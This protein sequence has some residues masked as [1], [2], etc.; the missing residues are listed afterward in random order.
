MLGLVFLGRQNTGGLTGLPSARNAVRN[1]GH[2]L[3][4]IDLAGRT[5]YC[6]GWA[7]DYAWLGLLF[8][9]AG[10]VP[11]FKLESVNRLLDDEIDVGLR[12]TEHADA[13][14]AAPGA[15]LPP[16]AA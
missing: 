3:R 6:D 16:G 5:V 12:L 11:R 4:V 14:P 13:P 7:H 8:E 9:E 15:S 1:S 2:H 10:L